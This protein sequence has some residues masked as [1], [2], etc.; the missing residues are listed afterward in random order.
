MS[1]GGRRWRWDLV[2]AKSSVSALEKGE[3]EKKREAKETNLEP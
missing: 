2:D 1:G 3:R